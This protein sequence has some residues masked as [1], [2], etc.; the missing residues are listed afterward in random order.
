MTTPRPIPFSTTAPRVG[1]FTLFVIIFDSND[2]ITT[3]PMIPAPPSP[4]HTPAL[5][6]YPH[7]SGDDLSDEDLS[8][9]TKS[10]HTQ[11]AST[12]VIH[13]SHIRP[14]STSLVL[15]SHPGKEFLMPLGYRATMN[16]WTPSSTWHLL[17]SSELPSSS[18]K[19]SIPLSPLL[20]PSVPPP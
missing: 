7:D 6:V 16:R 8:N 17:L 19:R 4:N 11:S 3:L 9:T 15:A 1:V 12:S 20:P 18:R 14:L 2:E 13:S 10:L 5:Y